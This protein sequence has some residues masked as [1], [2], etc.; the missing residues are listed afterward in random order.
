MPPS[1]RLGACLATALTLVIMT[2][3][4]GSIPREEFVAEMRS[5]GGGLTAA[6][7]RNAVG[8]FSKHY[9]TERLS[10]TRLVLKSD[11]A[12]VTA[13]LRVPRHPDQLDELTF[14]EDGLDGPSPV[15]TSAAD[16]LDRM[17]FTVQDMPGL[18]DVEKLVDTALA[19]TRYDGGYVTTITVTREASAPQITVA[20]SSPRADANVAFAADGRFTKVRR[21]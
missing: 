12:G 11:D 17:S 18:R 2:S 15:K 13:H 4:C 9:G 3:A 14:T 5:R 16:D 7:V 8:A 1:K 6:L 20:V 19:R 21:A 10:L